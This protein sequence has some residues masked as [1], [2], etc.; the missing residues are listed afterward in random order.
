MSASLAVWQCWGLALLHV[1]IVSSMAVLGPGFAP[2][3][4]RQQYGSVGAWLCSMSASS[5][6]WQCWGLALLHVCIVSSVAVLGPGFAPCLHRQQCGSV[7]AW[8]WAVNKR[9]FHT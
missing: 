8:L 9:T 5:A 7:G 3:L 2:C 6:V 1:C 4:H